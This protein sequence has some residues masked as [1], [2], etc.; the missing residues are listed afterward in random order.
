M[1]K[2]IFFGF[3]ITSIACYQGFYA[4]GGASGVGKATTS[5]VVLSCISVVVLDYILAALLL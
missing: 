3:A 1:I 2:G 5:T 4:T